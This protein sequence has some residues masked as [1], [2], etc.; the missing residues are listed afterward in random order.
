MLL[1]QGSWGALL[2]LFFFLLLTP[3]ILI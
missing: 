2:Y 3:S 1:D